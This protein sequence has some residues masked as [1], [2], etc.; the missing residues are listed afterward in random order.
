MAWEKKGRV[1]APDGGFWW[2]KSYAHLP[3]AVVLDDVVRVYYAGLDENKFGRIGY[4]DLDPQNLNRVLYVHPEPVLDIGEIGAFDDCGVVPSSIVSVGNQ[5]Y[6]YYIGFQRAEKVP[7]MLFSG[8]AISE[9]KGQSFK[10]VFKTPILDRTPDEPFSRGAPFVH[11]D[12]EQWKMWYWS[13]THWSVEGN[14]PHYNNV[15]R[16][17][18]SRDGISWQ[19][20]GDVCVAP[21]DGDEFAIGRPWVMAS[22]NGT[23]DMWYSIRSKTDLY[24]IGLARSSDGIQWE[25]ADGDVGITVS[26]EGWDSEMICY[27]VV[28]EINGQKVMFYNGNSHGK[29]GFGYAIWRD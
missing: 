7:Y 2:A 17:A 8:L 28:H 12:G 13:C 14:Q 1:Y 20:T 4:V 24:R 6:L 23:Y 11:F 25:R 5:L 16:H 15:I 9:D 22:D 10:R 3:T 26:D 18:T 21:Q 29:T 19:M 27:G